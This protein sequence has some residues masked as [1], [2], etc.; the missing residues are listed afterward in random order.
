VPHAARNW[1]ASPE[2]GSG[3]HTGLFQVAA[4]ASSGFHRVQRFNGKNGAVKERES[5]MSAEL[6]SPEKLAMLLYHYS[7]ALAPD[8]GLQP[9]TGPEWGNLPA[10]E[11]SRLVA[12]TR[13]ALLDLRSAPSHR[14]STDMTFPE[15]TG[16]SEGKECGC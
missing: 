9:S 16:G 13:L 3:D 11:R 7:E 10:G 8:F 14:S 5:R 6:V 15:L 4:G 1:N 12:A 2:T